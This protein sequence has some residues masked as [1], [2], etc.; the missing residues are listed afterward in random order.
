MVLI[1]MRKL[2]V[3]SNIIIYKTCPFR[4][5]FYCNQFRFFC[6]YL[7]FDVVCLSFQDYV[8]VNDLKLIET[9]RN[10]KSILSNIPTSLKYS[11]S[12][13]L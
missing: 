5:I 6:H 10:Y 1:D 11:N 3:L 8:K 4:S 2:F 9:Q 12:F 7:S 13:L